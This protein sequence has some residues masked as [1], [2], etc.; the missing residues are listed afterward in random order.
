M[1]G[2]VRQHECP[3]E[4]LCEKKGSENALLTDRVCQLPAGSIP[5]PCTRAKA[6]FHSFLI[7]IRPGED[8]F[9]NSGT[10]SAHQGLYGVLI[11]RTQRAKSEG[12]IKGI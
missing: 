1:H 6:L 7:N 4:I 9:T 8:S 11:E 3:T 12:K 10:G 5:A 2:T